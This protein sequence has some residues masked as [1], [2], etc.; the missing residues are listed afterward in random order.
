MNRSSTPS[1]RRRYAVLGAATL[2]AICGGGAQG[3]DPAPT[4]EPAPLPPAD[5]NALRGVDRALATEEGRVRVRV[6]LR[7]QALMAAADSP[8]FAKLARPAPDPAA[9]EAAQKSPVKITAVE[10]AAAIDSEGAFEDAVATLEDEAAKSDAD[11]D[12]VAA[13]VKR[14]GG[15][16]VEEEILPATVVARVDADAARRA[17]A[18]RR[19]RGD[20]GRAH[21]ATCDGRLG[22]LRWGA[23]LVGRR[24]HWRRG[25]KR[26]GARRRGRVERDPRPD[27]PC[28]LRSDD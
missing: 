5:T 22:R 15:H 14:T 3:S 26:R 24:I 13:E 27:A 19:R 4:V 8:R 20:R 10:T 12:V 21:A 16:V 25:R 6:I 18:A 2:T 28:L 7:E 23:E 9:R 1:R 11:V 17:R